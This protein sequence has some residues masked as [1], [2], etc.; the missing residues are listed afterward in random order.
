MYDPKAIKILFNK[1]KSSEAEIEYAKKE[2]L[3]H[4]VKSI[5]HDEGMK[6]L[7]KE[8]KLTSPQKIASNFLYSLSTRKLEYRIGLAAYAI[9]WKMPKH[10]FSDD[11]FPGYCSY[12]GD[13]IMAANRREFTDLNRWIYG[14]GGLVSGT[15]D[16][17][18]I[19]FI[20]SEVNK[21]QPKQPGEKD[22]NIFNSIIK[23]IT[24]STED[25]T[26][27]KFLKRLS[28]EKIIKSNE[29]ERQVLIETLGYMGILQNENHPGHF[30][31]YIPKVY[32]AN[33]T[34]RGDVAYPVEWW[35]TNDGINE[36][37]L[38]YW[39]GKLLK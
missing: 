29:Q 28:K 11:N 33:M 14:L 22:L 3:I 8:V 20:L 15:C 2:G 10:K 37:A 16:V 13:Q 34:T 23:L 26:A 7:I 38:D 19:A 25:L 5:S 18:N 1:H 35:T 30:E 17:V 6:W 24:S 12:C 4:D 9:A 31:E 36:L 27:P 32:Q 21:L 39:F